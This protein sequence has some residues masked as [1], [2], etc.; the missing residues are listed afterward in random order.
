MS[1]QQ[2]RQLD[3]ELWQEKGYAKMEKA[4]YDDD[5]SPTSKLTQN[6]TTVF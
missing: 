2:G 4:K 6:I 1:K 3:S 5:I